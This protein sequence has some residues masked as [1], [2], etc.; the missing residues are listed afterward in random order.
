MGRI[1]MLI[2]NTHLLQRKLN[3]NEYASTVN[4]YDRIV[5]SYVVIVNGWI[6]MLIRNVFVTKKVKC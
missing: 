1:Q 4:R 3:V 6:Q 2:G 5:N